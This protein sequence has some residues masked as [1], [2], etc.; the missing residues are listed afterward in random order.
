MHTN[1]DLPMGRR[2]LLES[3][4]IVVCDGSRLVVLGYA[5]GPRGTHLHIRTGRERHNDS[6]HSLGDDAPG[7][8]HQS[9]QHSRSAVEQTDWHDQ[10][11]R[12]F[13]MEIARELHD[14]VASGE[15]KSLVLVA[16]PRALGTL[17]ALLTRQ[18]ANAVRV[19]IDKDYARL[20]VPEIERL[21]T[22]QKLLFPVALKE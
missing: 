22:A 8:V 17:R 2:K 9:N 3:E 10:A 16:P 7:R 15:V 19:E 1:N 11:E 4:W 21:L 20:P 5:G 12:A 14:A 13:L 18:A 6:T